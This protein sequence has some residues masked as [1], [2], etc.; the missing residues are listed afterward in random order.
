[1]E[2]FQEYLMKLYLNTK[3]ISPEKYNEW[4]E[5]VYGPRNIFGY[6]FALSE[7]DEKILSLKLKRVDEY[8]F[9]LIDQLNSYTEITL[10]DIKNNEDDNITAI[11]T[12]RNE[13]EIMDLKINVTFIPQVKYSLPLVVSPGGAPMSCPFPDLPFEMDKSLFTLL[14]NIKSDKKWITDSDYVV[15]A[16]IIKSEETV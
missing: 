1:M 3:V 6:R 7:H 12:L 5:Q 11:L 9:D 16:K 2:S 8:I 13:L 10:H 4:E 14:E 15:A